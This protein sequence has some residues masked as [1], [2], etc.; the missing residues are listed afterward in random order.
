[1]ISTLNLQQLKDNKRLIE[2]AEQLFL[3]KIME[4]SDKWF[5]DE[6]NGA[7]QSATHPLYIKIISTI[8]S[9]E[10]PT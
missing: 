8:N 9:L 10:D 7:V 4:S 1:M 5:I 2:D 3:D 6:I